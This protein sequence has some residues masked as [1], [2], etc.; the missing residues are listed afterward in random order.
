MVKLKITTDIA[1]EL[2]GASEWDKNIEVERSIMSCGII[3]IDGISTTRDKYTFI[4]NLF[5]VLDDSESSKHGDLRTQ[6]FPV[7]LFSDKVRSDG[8]GGAKFARLL[9]YYGFG[10][11]TKS[12]VYV[13]PNTGNHIVMYTWI[14]NKNACADWMDY[15]REMINNN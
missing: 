6:M 9:S 4:L 8:N 14:P 13:N 5:E 10:K 1:D 7:F 11:V 3:E 15:V 12:K 2:I